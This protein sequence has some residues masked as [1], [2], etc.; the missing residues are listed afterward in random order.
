VSDVIANDLLPRVAVLEEIARGT[1]AVLDR[2]ERRLD[3]IEATQ[4]SQFLWLLGAFGAGYLSLLLMML[5]TLGL[6]ART[7][8]WI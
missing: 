7:Q 6:I 8:H 1:K 4:R 5:A 3:T 2:I